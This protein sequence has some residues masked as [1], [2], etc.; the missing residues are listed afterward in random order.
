MDG[1]VVFS[2]QNWPREAA[3][4][5]DRAAAVGWDGLLVGAAVDGHIGERDAA[6]GSAADVDIVGGLG[7]DGSEAEGG[8]GCG[9]VGVVHEGAT[10]RS[11]AA[12]GVGVGGGGVDQL[13]GAGGESGDG[14]QT[15]VISLHI[16]T[17]CDSEVGAGGTGVGEVGEVAGFGEFFAD[18]G[19]YRCGEV[20]VVTESGS[21]F[22]K[23]VEGFG[24]PINEV[25]D[26]AID[27]AFVGGVG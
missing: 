16:G 12:G 25:G 27:I 3:G 22:V 18:T 8:A 6:D 20:R 23:G 14:L 10:E 5:I 2:F 17:N 26:L 9:C 7:G 1:S 11:E 24:C 15:R 4:G 13:V 19:A 21:E